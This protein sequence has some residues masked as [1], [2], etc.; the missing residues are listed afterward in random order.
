[1]TL[2]QALIQVLPYL[3]LILVILLIGMFIRMFMREAHEKI[4]VLP[5]KLL[6]AAVLIF[7]IE[8]IMTVLRHAG[9]I[10]YPY[11]IVHGFFE[12]G[13]VTL[14]LY[15]VLIQKEHIIEKGY[16]KNVKK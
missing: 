15:M 10:D 7:V 4:Y 14:F 11:L 12:M 5:W 16:H 6:F 1:M 3:N 2:N 8:E 9:V 13:M